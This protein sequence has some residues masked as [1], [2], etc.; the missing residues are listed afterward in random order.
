MHK[1]NRTNLFTFLLAC[2]GISACADLKYSAKPCERQLL[3]GQGVVASPSQRQQT[4]S[5]AIDGYLPID[6]VSSPEYF[7]DKLVDSLKVVQLT[8]DFVPLVDNNNLILEM[9]KYEVTQ[10]QWLTVMGMLPSQSA[11][12]EDCPV[13]NLNQEMILLFIKRLNHFKACHYRLPSEQE[14]EFVTTAGDNSYNL[15]FPGSSSAFNVAWFHLNCSSVQPVGKLL[16]NEFGL[17]DLAGNVSELCTTNDGHTVSK[18]GCWFN[19]ME[20][21]HVQG[22]A[23][24][25]GSG[26]GG[27]FRLAWS[28]SLPEFEM[29]S[30]EKGHL[31]GIKIKEGM[32]TQLIK[33]RSFSC[34]K[35]E[36]TQAQWNQVMGGNPSEFKSDSKLPIESISLEE[37]QEFIRRVNI[38]S[39]KKY[40][41][42]TALE[43][44]YAFRGGQKTLCYAY[45]GSDSSAHVGWLPQNSESTTHPFGLKQPN[46]LGLYDFTGNVSEYC[47]NASWK[48]YGK[49]G[50]SWE[51]DFMYKQ[52]FW[53]MCN[54]L[55][56][57]TESSL[58]FRLVLDE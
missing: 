41:L 24:V 7:N 22:K 57:T 49:C 2:I 11:Y 34:M 15:P 5:L 20:A 38:L 23:N 56:A 54:P 25:N 31:Y 19:T 36:V 45:A 21:M 37:V 13:E 28:P 9:G 46:E 8:F 26:R 40:R 39:G 14:W 17:Y 18:G 27:G 53:S 42:P 3:N 47:F 51:S 29:A 6:S 16:P 32:A 33:V 55:I 52:D 30:V 10:K 35:Y 1:L 50:D 48:S 44:E 58:G 4:R 43:W 12:C